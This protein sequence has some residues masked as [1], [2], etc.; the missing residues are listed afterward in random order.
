MFK[1]LNNI[2]II[3]ISY[4][5]FFQVYFTV[6]GIWLVPFVERRKISQQKTI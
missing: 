1:Y 6:Y 3:D 5:F 4:I 2:K